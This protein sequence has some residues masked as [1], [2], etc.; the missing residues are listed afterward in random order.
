[1]QPATIHARW[2]A[3]EPVSGYSHLAGLVLGAI[4]A[5]AL[6]LCTRARPAD[7][8]VASVYGL[9]LVALYAASSA[10]HLAAGNERITRRLRKL[11][12]GAI[13][14]L[15]A[16]TCT[17]L[18]W[19]AFDGA[20]RTGMLSAVWGLALAGIAFRT[21][22]MGAPRLLYTIAYVAMGWLFMIQGPRG[23]HALPTVVIALVIAGGL[24]YMTGAV[25]YALKRPNPF[26][27]VFGF[28][29]IWHFFVLG[30]S[31][32]HYAAIATLVAS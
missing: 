2:R 8:A 24:T 11:D 28:H 25:V 27:H 30:G 23:L 13:F 18:F 12:H 9:S 19:R 14:L 5:L 21:F 17:P 32:L 1:M 16:G 29:E 26:P 3:R 6:V 31:A 10:Y 22:W 4:G 7:L 20:A 15:I